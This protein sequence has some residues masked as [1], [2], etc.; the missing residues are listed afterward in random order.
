MSSK[1]F[2][3]NSNKNYSCSSELRLG[4]NALPKYNN[5]IVRLLSKGFRNSQR[6]LDFGAGI[7]TLANIY[8]ELYGVLPDCYE[9]DNNHC[10]I[11]SSR[12]FRAYNSRDQIT[13]EY[14][15]IY[16]S[17]VLEHI[18][19][20]VE[21]LRWINKILRQGGT[22]SLYVPAHNCIYSKFD[23]M[24]GHYRRYDYKSLSEKLEISGFK[25]V[26]YKYVD[27]LGFFIWYLLKNKDLSSGS[28]VSSEKSFR[29]YDNYLL[30]LSLALDKIFCRFIGK[31]IYIRAVK[32]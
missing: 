24:A 31:N 21:A 1:S 15:A 4:E 28:G 6:I 16:S 18:E 9:V 2:Q 27:F 14:D 17:N 32:Y 12:N 19:D 29:F 3:S 26:E 25:I 23:E 7:G 5:Y 30:P 13:V 20:D 22:L 8:Q 11:I 10:A